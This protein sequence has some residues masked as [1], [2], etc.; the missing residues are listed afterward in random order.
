[1]ATGYRFDEFEPRKG[2]NVSAF[3]DLNSLKRFVGSQ[4]GTSKYWQVNGT[5]VKDEG[6]PDGLTIR[7]E[8]SR[9]IRV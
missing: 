5:V 9:Q 6:G 3:R 4:S 2:S 8:G 7:V 1:M